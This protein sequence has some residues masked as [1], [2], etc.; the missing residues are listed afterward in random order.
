MTDL[1]FDLTNPPSE[2][3]RQVR[4]PLL[5]RVAMCVYR[6]HRPAP[7]DPP[8]AC[9]TCGGGWPCGCRRLAERALVGAWAGRF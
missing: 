3:P 7:G 1:P 5:W 4:H 9:A 6:D 2:P 8:A